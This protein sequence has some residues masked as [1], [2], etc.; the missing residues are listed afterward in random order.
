MLEKMNS[1]E[2][3]ELRLSDG[4]PM[5]NVPRSVEEMGDAI[6]ETRTDKSQNGETIFT[7]IIQRA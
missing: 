6:V 5:E 4:E 1:G 7:L 3:L 2:R